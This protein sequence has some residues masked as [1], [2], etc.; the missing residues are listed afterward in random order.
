MPSK[1]R[2]ITIDDLWSMKRIGAPSLSPDGRYACVAV[3]AFDMKENKSTSQLWL[4]S[5]D[6][7]TQRQLSQ[8]KN[9]SEP[10]WS[11]DG[12]WIAFLSKRQDESDKDETQRVRLFVIAADG[13][14]ARC[15]TRLETGA[16]GLRWF[17]DSRQLAFI[18]WVWPELKSEKAQNQRAQKE[19]KDKV[20]ATVVEHN[21]YRYWDHWFARGRRPHLIVV[22]L[23]GG[24]SRDLFAGSRFHFPMQEPSA[25]SYDISPDC[26]EVAFTY[27]FDPDP[28]GPSLT[29]IVLI[30]LK[31][32]KWRCPTAD[33]GRSEEHPRYSPDGR[34]I[35]Y[36]TQDFERAYNDQSRLGVIERTTGKLRKLTF[37]WDRSVN[38]GVQ[39]A[40]DS[41]TVYFTAETEQIQPIWRMRMGDAR[42]TEVL[43]GTGH[44]GLASAA[45]L[46]RDGKTLVYLRAS[47][48][49][50]P[51][52]F[53]AAADGRRERPIETFNRALL[54]KLK[55][56]AAESHTVKGAHGEAVQMWVV[57]PPQ[58]DKRKRWPLLQVIHGGPH[59]CS[60]DAWHWRWNAQLFAAAGYVVAEVNYH[61]STG[62]GQ[63]F[64][65]SIDGDWGWRE[66]ADIEAGTNYLLKA[67][68]IDPA[69]IVASGG[70]YG[71]YM[72]AY[73]NGNI[74]GD[75]YK[76][77]V[78]HAGCYD[79]V[80]MMAS[81]G[82]HYFARELGAY[83]WDDEARVLKQSPHHYAKNFRTPTLVVHGALDYRVPYEQ[84]LAYYNTLRVKKVPSRLVYFPDEN[85]W[86][87]KP[88]NSRL[89]Y[90]EFFDWCERFTKPGTRK[91]VAAR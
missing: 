69:R 23:E 45:A 66:M 76:A 11:P 35:S 42:P 38:A 33:T 72:V 32:G 14:E 90:K 20:K 19:K 37:G 68:I 79:W 56:S 73:M 85:H 63:K 15:V 22:D 43:R 27:D 29:D 8:G 4:L 34:W 12:R 78:C 86:I 30:D 65:S 58:F 82:Y 75:R 55:L 40:P 84:G 67:G 1:K 83:H 48:D 60:N 61:G 39:W 21:H 3:A 18:S 47:K 28:G 51:M 50:P 24:K 25:D 54:D 6:G 59:T 26:G 17:P 91:R 64:I 16:Q 2:L 36:L 10:Q 87:L 81:D 74:K 31:S 44:G 7:T 80:S 49:H 62:W 71:G 9:D 46:S 53:A 13:G 88:Q 5:T 57:K 89:W 77:Y 41:R 70:S 52:L